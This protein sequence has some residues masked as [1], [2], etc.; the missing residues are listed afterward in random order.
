[1]LRTTSLVDPNAVV[2][3]GLRSAT[4]AYS[5]TKFERHQ[6]FRRLGRPY[7]RER[8]RSSLWNLAGGDGS[9]APGVDPRLQRGRTADSR[10]SLRDW[11]LDEDDAGG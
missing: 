7:A 10:L 2:R 4:E 3:Q 1:M 6:G 11:L 5:L 9:G 8:F